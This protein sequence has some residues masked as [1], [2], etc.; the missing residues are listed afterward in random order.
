MLSGANS[1]VVQPDRSSR[2]FVCALTSLLLTIM[3]YVTLAVVFL[4]SHASNALPLL[5]RL[6]LGAITLY[7]MVAVHLMPIL[8]PIALLL[9]IVGFFGHGNTRLLSAA[10]V[11][12]LVPLTIIEVNWLPSLLRSFGHGLFRLAGNIFEGTVQH[13]EALKAGVQPNRLVGGSGTS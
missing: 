9:A 4:S 8:T 6:P 12:L 3:H 1:P 2:T 7:A 5:V 11:V 13:A 10:S